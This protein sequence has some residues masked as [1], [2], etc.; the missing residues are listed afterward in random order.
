MRVDLAL[1][2]LNYFPEGITSPSG[3]DVI[4]FLKKIASLF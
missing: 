2:G 3:Y 4:A 1:A